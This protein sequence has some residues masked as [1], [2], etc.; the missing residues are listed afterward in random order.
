MQVE[1]D[2]AASV[3]YERV[4]SKEQELGYSICAQQELLRPYAGEQSLAIAQEFVDVETA[5]TAGRPGFNAMVAYLKAHP[6][7]RVLLVEKTDRLYRNF[8]DYVT[9]DDLDLTIHFVKEGFV[10]SKE[11]RSS[12]KF[13]HG[14]KVLMAKNYIDNLSEEVQKG[15]HTK[16]EQGL[17]PSFAPIGYVNT[18]ATSG[19]RVIVPD[20]VL[21]PLITKL[22]SWFAGGEYSLKELAKKA[23]AEGFRFRVSR[24]KIPVAT[25]HKIM[26]R[27]IYM[28][29]FDYAGR[30]Y[31]GIHEPL[32][33]RA[34]WE[35]VQEI[36]DRRHQNKHRKV[37]HDFAYSGAI[38]CGHCGCSLVGEI[39]KKRYVYYHCTGYKGKCPEPYVREEVLEKQFAA[40]LHELVIPREVLEWLQQELVAS[41]LTERAAREQALRRE[42]TEVER[43]QSRLDVL[44]EDRLDG[45][46]DA[47]T[48]DKRAADIRQQQNEIR[49]RVN[50]RQ[51][52]GLPPASQ[53]VDLL[54]L[55][56]KAADLFLEQP[57][58]EQAKLLHLV[59]KSASWKG[60]ELRM[61]LREPFSKLRLS[62]S[63]T[64]TKDGKLAGGNDNS[65]IWR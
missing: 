30:T 49:R 29:E 23:Y 36:L 1:I 57:A 8:K 63:V 21:G 62:N 24:T 61:C 64:D 58:A 22:Y 35:R 20:P 18:L 60:G 65:N 11:S 4:S 33:E 16:A 55:T 15:L 6:E 14:I 10:L 53:A 25:L 51:S 40:G 56:S 26:R 41:D 59:L 54:A 32:V 5:K 44:Y 28:G 37:T 42:Q 19:K 17:F 45:R 34:T 7:C 9:I 13:M 50:E 2:P 3:A 39:K 38:S 46:I 47:S 48:Y 43:L 12:E 31:Q 52:A 27:R